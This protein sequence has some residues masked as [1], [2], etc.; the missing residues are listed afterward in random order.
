VSAVCGLLLFGVHTEPDGGFLV[1]IL[2]LVGAPRGRTGPFF[3]LPGRGGHLGGTSHQV[4]WSVEARG[5]RGGAPGGAALSF[6]PGWAAGG[7]FS[8]G[9][10]SEVSGWIERARRARLGPAK[11]KKGAPLRMKI[12]ASNICPFE[13]RAL[14]VRTDFVIRFHESVGRAGDYVRSATYPGN[15]NERK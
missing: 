10:P 15:F 13:R 7:V 12:Q 5:S 8:R 3:C 1:R 2:V 6:A 14:R 9:V 4:G 11:N